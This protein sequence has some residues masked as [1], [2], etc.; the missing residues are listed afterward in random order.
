LRPYFQ[1]VVLLLSHA[2]QLPASPE[3]AGGKEGR[4]KEKK[5]K[6]EP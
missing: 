5:K 1:L 6:K 2:L 3:Q 4:K